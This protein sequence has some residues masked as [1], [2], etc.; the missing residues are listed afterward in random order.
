MV[1]PELGQRK[2]AV[3][4]AVVE[5]YVRTG[6]PVGSET[7]AERSG[8][9]VSS[10]TIRNELAALEEL[11]YLMHPHT[12][13]G[14][15]PT[16]AGYRKFVDSLPP[17]GRLRDKQRR[18]IAGFFAETMLDLEEVLKGTTQLLS[19]VTQYAGLAVP[20]TG[21]DEVVLR[22]ELLEVGNA[23]MFLVVGQQGRVDKAMIDRP[24]NVDSETLSKLDRALSG[25]FRGKSVVEARAEAL[26]RASTAKGLERSLLVAAADTFGVLQ[27]GGATHHVLI[28]GVANLADEAA[29][30][31]RETVRRLFEALEHESE[32][33][34][35]LRDVTIDQDVNVTIGT[36]HPQTGDW[37]A[38]IVS[39][40]FRAGTTALGAVG[41]VGPTA[42]D[43][44][45]V[46]ASVR[47]V[48]KRLSELA[49]E[50]GA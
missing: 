47:A 14:R 6:E 37:E 21:A 24:E 18:A 35:L 34:E 43:Y 16:D 30:W 25:A 5:E 12:S 10:A 9:G 1:E 22:T 41:V 27:A 15:I 19:R 2:V 48:A 23:L 29:H 4:R 31:R 49:T 39:A 13:A 3:L 42:M 40:P 8:L 17:G 36:E 7:I 33:L 32:M 26:K 44:V 46:M 11:G 28:G 50:L 38:S 45:S 20:P